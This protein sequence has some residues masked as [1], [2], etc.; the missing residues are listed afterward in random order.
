MSCSQ[1]TLA[2]D[3]PPPANFGHPEVPDYSSASEQ[4]SASTEQEQSGANG[5]KR[6]DSINID[7]FTSGSGYADVQ[8]ANNP[9]SASQGYLDVSTGLTGSTYLDVAPEQGRGYNAIDV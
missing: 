3:T 7:M 6:S 4:Y 2:D 9:P 5:R 8:P 1:T